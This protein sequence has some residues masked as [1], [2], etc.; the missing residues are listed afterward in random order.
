MRAP[1]SAVARIAGSCAAK[2]PDAIG[3]V[4]LA[5]KKV[6]RDPETETAGEI[7]ADTWVYG[8]SVVVRSSSAF[9]TRTS[10]DLFCR[11]PE[12]RNRIARR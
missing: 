1:A 11:A 6:W 8:I 12:P 2:M 5:D 10:P 4:W 3:G 9:V 7:P